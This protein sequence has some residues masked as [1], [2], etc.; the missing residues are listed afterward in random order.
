MKKD[1]KGLVVKTKK[2]GRATKKHSTK[3]G[4]KKYR[5]PYKGQGRA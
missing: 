5:K 4:S 2:K 1:E 3:K